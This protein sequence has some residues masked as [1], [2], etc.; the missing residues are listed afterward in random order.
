MP[1][2]GRSPGLACE[3]GET[4]LGWVSKRCLPDD[5]GIS[6]EQDKCSKAG[7]PASTVKHCT[8]Q[9]REMG[10][11]DLTEQIRQ[12]VKRS[13]IANGFA[14]VFVVGATGAVVSIEYEDGLLQDFEEALARLFPKRPDY[15]HELAWHDGNAHSHLRATLLG[16]QL[17]LPVSNGK[18][19]LGT[20]QNIAVVNLDS[21][22][23][24][25]EIVVTIFG[26]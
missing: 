10:T 16:P 5:G 8:G 13:M 22:A 11:A 12:I 24:E 17:M 15:H 25:R 14:H 21:R 26:E 19:D 9:Q 3:H 23:R 6:K 2:A 20:W 4:S 18:P 7:S 1:A